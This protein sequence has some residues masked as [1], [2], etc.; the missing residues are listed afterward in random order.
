MEIQ[1][2]LKGNSEGFVLQSKSLI[3][4]NWVDELGIEQDKDG[5]RLRA[6]ADEIL[7]LKHYEYISKTER[8]VARSA[9]SEIIFYEQKRIDRLWEPAYWYG[10]FR[11]DQDHYELKRVAS[12]TKGDILA[13]SKNGRPIGV[14]AAGNVIVAGKRHFSLYT[15]YLEEV[16][17]LL[18]FYVLNYI[19]G[20][21]S[22][23][24]DLLQVK[25]RLFYAFNDR[26]ALTKEH[27]EMLPNSRRPSILEAVF[28][29]CL[30]LI[31]I[32]IVGY[33]SLK[34]LMI[35]FGGI[36]LY[37][38]YIFIKNWREKNG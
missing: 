5:Y 13:I 24:I 18:L 7:V 26:S 31:I 23:D 16:E 3:A 14:F 34:P 11:Y 6:G 32:G 30:T 8:I 4:D 9:H 27:L 10:I 38:S 29:W 36:I 25:Y 20:L 12:G 28:W 17:P 37:H 35:F 21:E 2:R 1:L 33:I 22:L 19:R 15:E